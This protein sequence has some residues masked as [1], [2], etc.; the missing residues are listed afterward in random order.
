MANR[1]T[2]KSQYYHYLFFTRQ[3][4]PEG[5]KKNV[6]EG[7]HERKIIKNKNSVVQYINVYTL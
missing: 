1:F 6:V 7:F 3:I 5:F 2:I 4:V